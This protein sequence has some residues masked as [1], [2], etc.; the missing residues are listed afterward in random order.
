[1]SASQPRTALDSS[2][3]IAAL[4][5]TE[6][7]HVECLPLLARKQLSVAAHALAETFSM[8]S[9]GQGRQYLAPQLVAASLKL[10]VLPRVTITELTTDDYQQA[11]GEAHALGVRGGAI[12]DYLHL[13]AARKAQ[14]KRLYT[15]NVSDFR[16]FARPGDP[17]ILHPADAP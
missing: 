5:D 17:A 7:H 4:R 3:L 6:A 12:Y 9:S 14:A 11:I 16:A 1:M 2:V 13:K 15:L 8:L 10:S